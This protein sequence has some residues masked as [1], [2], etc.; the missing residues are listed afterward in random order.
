MRCLANYCRCG[1]RT[2]H[3]LK[4][5][6]VSATTSDHRVQV[7]PFVSGGV[8]GGL[9]YSQLKDKMRSLRREPV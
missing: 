6:D 7:L 2:L 5:A 4:A 1:Q 3:A 9:V 8:I